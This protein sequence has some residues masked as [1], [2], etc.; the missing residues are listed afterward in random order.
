MTGKTNSVNAVAI[1][2]PPAIATAIGPQ[3]ILRMSGNIPSI[4]AAA[5]NIIG[6]KRRTAESIIAS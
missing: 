5:V 3:K 2:S 4:A 1:K 6:R